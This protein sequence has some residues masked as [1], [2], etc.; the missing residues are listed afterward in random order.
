MYLFQ[1]NF[2]ANLKRRLF[3]AYLSDMTPNIKVGGAVILP[4][5]DATHQRGVV[6]DEASSWW[7]PTAAVLPSQEDLDDNHQPKLRTKDEE[8]KIE[9]EMPSEESHTPQDKPTSSWKSGVHV[10]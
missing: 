2:A 8:Q 7:L 1:K 4:P 5:T 3:G 10:T 6:F 9:V